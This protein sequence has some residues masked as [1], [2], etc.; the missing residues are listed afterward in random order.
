MA[1]LK[2]QKLSALASFR[3]VR[4]R[5]KARVR[6]LHVFFTVQ[7]CAILQQSNWSSAVGLLQNS[8]IWT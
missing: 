8:T 5:I 2:N 6:A 7:Y 3:R 1:T 4:L